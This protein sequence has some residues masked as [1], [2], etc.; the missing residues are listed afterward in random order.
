LSEY[1]EQAGRRFAR[2]VTRAVVA[3]PWLWRVFRPL[4]RAQFDRLASIWDARRGPEAH[5]ALEAAFDRLDTEPR[6]V[7]DVGTGTGQ[8]ARYI[9]ARF[10]AADV[11]A[12]D[13]SPAMIEEA[14]RLLPE[15]I[16]ER[17]R[18]E[19]A[20]AAS[21][22]FLDGA[23][24]L[25]VLLNMIP[26]FDEIARVTALGGSV[27]F[28]FS[29]GPE[30]PIYTPPETLRERLAPRGFDRFEEFAAEGGTALLARRAEA[31]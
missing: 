15:E 1:L 14:R 13:Q 17:V 8:G 19:V 11:V 9:A 26:F 23:F 4:M 16:R 18:F 30:T 29:S 6:R 22:P 12:V 27:V 24:D 5:A 25:L 7:L 10:R 28:A 20:D 21:L 3:R 31:G 2:L